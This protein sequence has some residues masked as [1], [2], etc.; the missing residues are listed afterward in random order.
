[1]PQEQAVL[2]ALSRLY[3]ARLE[4]IELDGLRSQETLLAGKLSTK[5]PVAILNRYAL[6]SL[7]TALALALAGYSFQ[8]FFFTESLSYGRATVIGVLALFLVALAWALYAHD[9]YISLVSQ[10]LIGELR[11]AS[12]IRHQIDS[13]IDQLEEWCS[14]DDDSYE[15]SS[16]IV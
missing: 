1:M 7:I 15:N 5:H 16:V 6:R 2:A 13:A 9:H 10:R 8:S 14:S 12:E 3:A 4:L 11:A